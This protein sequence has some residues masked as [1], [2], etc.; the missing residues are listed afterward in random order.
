MRPLLTRTGERGTVLPSRRCSPGRLAGDFVH[1]TS[2]FGVRLLTEPVVHGPIDDSASAF[3]LALNTAGARGTAGRPCPRGPSRW[4]MLAPSSHW[5][6]AASKAATAA[7]IS[8]SHPPCALLVDPPVASAALLLPGVVLQV[9]R[10]AFITGRRGGGSRWRRHCRVI[11]TR[12]H[13]QLIGM[14]ISVASTLSDAGFS[15]RIGS[16]ITPVIGVLHGASD[17]G[18]LIQT[19]RLSMAT[20]VRL[21]LLALHLFDSRRV[22]TTELQFCTPADPFPQS[23]HSLRRCFLPRSG[24]RL[25][26]PLIGGSVHFTAQVPLVLSA[27]GICSLQ[28]AIL[29]SLPDAVTAGHTVTKA[30]VVVEL[31]LLVLK[32]PAARI[33]LSLLCAE[34]VTHWASAPRGDGSAIAPML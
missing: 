6:S 30:P 17:L 1:V 8:R 22:S 26:L 11:F 33:D 7:G 20:L 12:V 34:A 31:S 13:S 16:G 5:G 3:T 23:R 4:L 2:T 24:S 21:S 15:S 25:R 32:C 9:A 28:V 19:C 14:P 10:V 27:V 29:T 18:R